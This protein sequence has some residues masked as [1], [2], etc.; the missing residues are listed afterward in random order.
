[1]INEIK[2]QL[3]DILSNITKSNMSR[4]EAIEYLSKNGLSKEKMEAFND[5]LKIL[6]EF[7]VGNINDLN[8]KKLDELTKK[9]SPHGNIS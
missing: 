5:S 6:D 8:L 1:M 9:L 4:E 7:K 2:K 3:D